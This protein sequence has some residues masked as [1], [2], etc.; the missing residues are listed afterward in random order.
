METVGFSAYWA[1]S[2]RQIPDKGDLRDYWIGISSARDFLGTAPSYTVIQDPI[3]WMCHRLI[4]CS[5]AGRSQAPKKVTVTDLFYLR[6]MDVGLVNVPY[7]LAR[8]LRLFAAGMKSG[9]HISGGKFLAQLAKHFGLLTTEILQGLTVIA[10]ALSVIDMAKQP[11][12]MA[13]ALEAAEDAS[14][15]DEGGQAVLAPVQAPQP[16]PPLVAARTMPQRLGR[17]EEEMQRLCRDVRSLRGLMKR[18]MTDQGRFST[19]MTSCMAQLME[20][21]GLTYQDL[22]KEISTNIGAEFTNL[23]ILKCWSLETSRRMFN[24]K[25]CSIKLNMENLPSKI[26]GEF[27]N[28]ILFNSRI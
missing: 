8:Y 11:D 9:A 4:A 24:M 16:L 12:A 3:L 20:A 17:L 22:V 1:D 7:L 21:G 5:I 13:G 2:A 18:S 26:S 25:S 23:E 27:V 15:D 14:I 19:W 28:L 6:G 10:P